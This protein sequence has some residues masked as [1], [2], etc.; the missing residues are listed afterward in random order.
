[1]E[2]HIMYIDKYKEF[3]EKGTLDGQGGKALSK[4]RFFSMSFAFDWFRK[5]KHSN[6]LELGTIHSF[7][8]GGLPGC[9]C[10]DE[11]YWDYEKP[12]NWDWGAGCFSLMAAEELF[13]IS[14][15]IHTVDIVADHI[16][17]CRVI[18]R[19]FT[20]LF[21]YYV[22][23]SLAYLAN[24]PLFFDLIYLDTGFM[25]PIEPTANL[26]L[27]EVKLIHKRNLLT[28]NGIIVIGDVKNVN[29]IGNGSE[30]GKSKYSIPYLLKNKYGIII[31]EY[32]VVL[33]HDE[34]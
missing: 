14:P 29:I 32:Q 25:N 19:K 22:S 34:I 23:D 10:N 21:H 8:N 2:N 11:K 12:V 24:T 5:N 30:L 31:D 9:D 1:M 20:S 4:S 26:Q 27:E 33:K 15:N 6:I 7:V 16:N 18:T 3:L 13:N 28:K 17:R